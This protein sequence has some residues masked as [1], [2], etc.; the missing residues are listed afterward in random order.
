MKKRRRRPAASLPV[1]FAELLA[2]SSETVLR[3]GW[4][5][6]CGTCSPA[7]YQRMVR[8]KMLAAQES[9]LALARGDAAGAAA[10]ALAPWHRRATANAR[11]LRRR[12]A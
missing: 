1:M 2:A 4:M 8:E 11:R 7:E 5:I 6:S 10:S 3:R 9:A 12:K